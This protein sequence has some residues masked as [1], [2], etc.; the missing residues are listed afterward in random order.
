MEI[1]VCIKQVPETK[2]VEVD[3]DGNL[4]REGVDSIMNPYD[5]YALETGLRL[6]EKHD[7]NV[8]VVTMGPPQAKEVI[9]EAYMTGADEGYIL[10]DMKFAGAD[11][12]ATS[13]TLAQGLE[14][15]DN[16]KSFDLIICGMESIDG[17][18]AQVGPSI[19]ETLGIPHVSY[20]SDLIDS[21]E[22][23][24]VVEKDMA[25]TIAEV[26]IEFPALITVTKAVGQP[27]LPSYRLKL[28]TKYWDINCLSFDDMPDDDEENFGLSGSPTWVEEVF[29][30]PKDIE[31]VIWDDED[32][33]EL[34]DKFY[35]E[36]KELKFV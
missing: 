10:S 23:K 27:R 22:N 20:V 9:K 3:E 17:D 36:L 35:N 26:E 15:I 29:P 24:L 32:A 34:T 1:L 21:D 6:K 13:Y 25:E 31:Q 14:V 19:A 5:L 18:T 30:P 12:L 7:G 4:I 33:E 2:D 16:E 8:T 28:E 11:T